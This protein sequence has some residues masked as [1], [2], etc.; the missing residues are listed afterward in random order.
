LV[1]RPFPLDTEG[2]IMRIHSSKLDRAFIED[3]ARH[4]NV[5]V[6][7][8]SEHTSRS[9]GRA[10][11]VVLTGSSGHKSQATGDNAAT[12]DEW[13][14]FLARLFAIDPAAKATYYESG[15]HFHWATGNRFMNLFPSQQHSRHNWQYGGQVVPGAFSVSECSCGALQR[16]LMG[17]RKFADIV[18]A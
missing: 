9:H 16:S 8:Y 14:I 12:W 15:E 1:A 3:A 7:K 13:G 6:A 11:E 18:S 2:K 4:A 5:A 17:G 10:F